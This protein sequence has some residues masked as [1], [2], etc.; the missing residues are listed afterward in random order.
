MAEAVR[1]QIKNLDANIPVNN[2]RSLNELTERAISDQIL[3]ARLSSCFC[4]PGAAAGG[5][6]AVRN[7]FILSGGTDT[8]NWRANGSGRA[9]RQRAENDFAGSRNTCAAGSGHRN[10][11]SDIGEPAFFVDAVWAE[12]HR[13]G[14]HA[15]GD[16]GASGDH[17]AGQL[18]SGAAGDE[19]GSDD[20]VAVRIERLTVLMQDGGLGG[21]EKIREKSFPRFR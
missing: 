14:F 12:R 2:I 6:W 11:V 15:V 17:A 13:S 4:R 3:I 8:R 20:R 21:H 9:A 1:K 7:P 10:T 18:Y 16:R 5:D 19:S